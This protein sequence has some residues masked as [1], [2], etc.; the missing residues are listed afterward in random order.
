MRKHKNGKKKNL[1]NISFST[2]SFDK[3]ALTDDGIYQCRADAIS[4][5]EVVQ[6]LT[7]IIL[8]YI[9]NVYFHINIHL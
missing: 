4:S 9:V 6:V 1:L 5:S 7:L 3:I 2:I 8:N